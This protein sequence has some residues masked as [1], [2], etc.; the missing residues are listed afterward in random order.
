MKHQKSLLKPIAL[1]LLS[2]AASA[3]FAQDKE[4][5]TI[6]ES[7]TGK[8]S[9]GLKFWNANWESNTRD[10]S[11]TAAQRTGEST[12]AITIIPTI[13]YKYKDF[14]ISASTML[15]KNFS[16]SWDLT[17]VANPSYGENNSGILSKD[18]KEFDI[19]FSYFLRPNISVSM[20][21]KNLD[22]PTAGSSYKIEGPIIG[23]STAAPLTE[24][25]SI[26][27]N[28][29]LGKMKV[30]EV[31]DA[32]STYGLIETGIAYSLNEWMKNSAITFSYRQ[33][34]VKAS[35]SKSGYNSESTDTTRG[36]AI[37]FT[38]SF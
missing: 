5:M 38:K 10:Y 13:Q 37:G 7:D 23:L 26:Y 24:N 22:F 36:V 6:P 4:A 35:V 11:S 17:F 9:I 34:E 29:G 21:Y 15:L 33:Q 12:N 1:A 25:T 18:R 20:G 19:N 8:L 14:A 28:I 2:L 16:T 31:P 30:K 27:A 32:S 3:A